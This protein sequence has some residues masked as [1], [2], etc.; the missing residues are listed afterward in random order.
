MAGFFDADG[1]ISINQETHQLSITISQKI[2]ELLL[3]IQKIYGGYIY[4]DRS[5]NTFI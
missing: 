3:V 4:I 5:S 2:Q 1:S